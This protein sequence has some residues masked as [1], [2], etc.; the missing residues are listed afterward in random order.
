M[1]EETLL[2]GKITKPREKGKGGM[3]K[4]PGL[5]WWLSTEDPGKGGA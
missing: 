1:R 3:T 5:P 2:L 4:L